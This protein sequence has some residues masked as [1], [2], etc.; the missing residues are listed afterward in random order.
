MRTLQTAL[1]KQALSFRPDCDVL[2]ALFAAAF[3]L[4]EKMD[5][6]ESICPH[7]ALPT[8]VTNEKWAERVYVFGGLL[9]FPHVLH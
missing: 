8:N 4:S 2:T 7:W 9:R 3:N 5:H 1:F 6:P